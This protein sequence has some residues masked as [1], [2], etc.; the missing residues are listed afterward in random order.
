MSIV[1][2]ESVEIYEGCDLINQQGHYNHINFIYFSAVSD[3]SGNR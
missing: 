3:Q 2:K 1:V